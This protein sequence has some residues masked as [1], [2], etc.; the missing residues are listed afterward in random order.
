MILYIFFMLLIIFCVSFLFYRLHKM[1]N[2]KHMTLGIITLKIP[3]SD[4]SDIYNISK[5]ECVA[6]IRPIG[7]YYENNTMEIEIVDI[8][9]FRNNTNRDKEYAKNYLKKNFKLIPTKMVVWQIYRPLLLI[10]EKEL[11]DL[12]NNKEITIKDSIIRLSKKYTHD[13]LVRVMVK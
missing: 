11:H 1:K 3:E 7:I 6:K 9:N 12:L 8:I 4:N 13:E 2:K 5:C 10:E